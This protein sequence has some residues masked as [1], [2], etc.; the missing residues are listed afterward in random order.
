VSMAAPT[1]RS[2]FASAVS[3]ATSR[4]AAHH[5]MRDAALATRVARPSTRRDQHH[6]AHVTTHGMANTPVS[7]DI[8]VFPN[9]W[10]AQEEDFEVIH[11]GPWK[12][13][14]DDWC[15]P[16]G[17]AQCQVQTQYMNGMD[18]TDYSHNRTR[19]DDPK[20]G[21]I[22][23]LYFPKYMNMAVDVNNTCVNYCPIRGDLT[24]YQI[25]V[26]A[27]DM[28]PKVIDGRNT[29]EYE[30]YS[31]F[32]GVV[33][34]ETYDVYVDATT[35]L[36]Y[37]EIDLITPFGENL[38]IATTTY[39]TFVP[40]TPDPSLFDIKGVDSCPLAQNC[41]HQFRQQI[42]RHRRNFVDYFHY[43]HENNMA[44]SL[45]AAKAKYDAKPAEPML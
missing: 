30:W 4:A 27:T 20:Q 19:F 39:H 24:P 23:D 8:P 38:G 40:G 9:D 11:Q 31:T 28:G 2:V 25:N 6:H 35:K 37:K 29:E 33:V 45:A 14:G 1:K 32:E 36:P 12:Q 21:T 43:M 17:V 18:Y 3:K 34:M 7:R 44:S 15:C 42:R 41:G 5:S 22:V 10:S 26:N 13:D 16:T